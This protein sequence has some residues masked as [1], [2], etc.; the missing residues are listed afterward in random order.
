M[1]EQAGYD[2]IGDIH[3]YADELERLLTKLGY[4]ES[5]GVYEHSERSVVFLGDFID[6]GPKIPRVLE[7]ARG[8]VE[9]GKAKAVMGNHEFN[10]LAFHT[11]IEDSEHQTLRQRS[12]KNIRQHAATLQQ[13]KDGP[14]ADSLNWFRT[15]PMWTQ[16]EGPDGQL[17]RAVH[18]C[19]DARS[20]EQISKSLDQHGG[21]NSAFLADAMNKSHALYEAVEVVLKGKELGLPDGHSFLD[22]DGH[23]HNAIRTRWF[24]KPTLG[25]KYQDYVLQAD[26]IDCD[27]MIASEVCDRIEPY[28]SDAPPCFAGHYWLRADQPERLSSKVACLDYSVAKD[29]YLCAYRWDGE[30]EI[31]NSKFVWTN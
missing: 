2:L 3:G 5:N 7:I 19:W 23:S 21:T 15:L 28:P 30:Q 13:L 24:E 27:V 11:P 17:C 18:A 12:N 9:A 8:M 29:G 25:A 16:I 22:K 4:S 6:R 10:A 20:M 1:S 31:D 26:P 14:L